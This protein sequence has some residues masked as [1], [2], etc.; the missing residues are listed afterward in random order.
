M[1]SNFKTI[2]Y[3]INEFQPLDISNNHKAEKFI[4][5]QFNCSYGEHASDQLRQVIVSDDVRVSLKISDLTPL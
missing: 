2:Y 5:S 1:I 4:S 3:F